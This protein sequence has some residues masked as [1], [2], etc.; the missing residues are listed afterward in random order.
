MDTNVKACPKRIGDDNDNDD[1]K[2]RRSF[3]RKILIL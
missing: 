2:I 1:G 3:N